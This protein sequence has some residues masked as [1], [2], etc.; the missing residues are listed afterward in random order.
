MGSAPG[1]YATQSY[2]AANIFLA[3]IK[4]GKLTRNAMLNWVKSGPFPGVGGASYKFDRNGD[5]TEGG[6]NGFVVT[7][8]K[9]VNKGLVK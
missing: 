7:S 3:G 2:D 8:G 4:A 6:F 1:V 5:I 9:L